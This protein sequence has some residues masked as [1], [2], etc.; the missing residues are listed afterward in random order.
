VLPGLP[1]ADAE[2]LQQPP[3]QDDNRHDIVRRFDR[4]DFKLFAC[5]ALPARPNARNG[6]SGPHARI[7][8]NRQSPPNAGTSH[9]LADLKAHTNNSS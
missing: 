1:A 4:S 6:C 2:D 3:L 7:D 5:P 8:L 9:Q